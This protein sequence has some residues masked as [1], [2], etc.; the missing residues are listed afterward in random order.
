MTWTQPALAWDLN[1]PASGLQSI[2]EDATRVVHYR[3]MGFV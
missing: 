2:L 3:E 1:L